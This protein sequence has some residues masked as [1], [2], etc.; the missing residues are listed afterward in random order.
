MDDI[1]LNGIIDMHVHTAP[2]IRKRPYDDF[3]LTEAAVRVGARAI[4]IKCHHG[5][6]MTR[7]FMANEY[8]RIMHHNTNNFTMLGS[9]TLN[10]DVGGLNPTAVETALKLGAKVVW[11]PTTHAAN[12]L[13]KNGKTGGIQ[14]LFKGKI[15]EP[16]KEIFKMVKDYNVVLATGHL[17]PDE[18]FAVVDQAKAMGIGK[19]VITHPEFWVVG[20]SHKEQAQL[21][22]DYGVYL[23]RCYA[24]PMGGGVYKKNLEDNLKIIKELGC[25]NII[26][27]TDSG[28]MENPLW[29]KALLEYLQYLYCNGIT[30][31]EL[32]IMTHKTQSMLL[33]LETC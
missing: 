17:S 24:Q 25:K 16:L 20:L 11:L 18:I 32:G 26:I 1:S 33:D 29:E 10:Y 19:I 13:K 27:S 14:C 28:Q 6:T 23:E 21:V 31:D 7:A 8:N 4:V 9:I 15:V 5:A 3:E 12:Q 22:K 2:D 30:K